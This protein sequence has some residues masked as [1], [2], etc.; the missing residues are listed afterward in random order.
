MVHPLAKLG[1]YFSIPGYF[2][3]ERKNRHRETFKRIPLDRLLI[4][5][6]APDQL[7]PT[8][9]NRFPLSD[10]EGKP[11]NHPANI[12]E[13]YAFVADLLNA[14]VEQVAAKIAQNFKNLFGAS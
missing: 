4:E 1:A 5:T 6:D 11:I 13:V 14:P 8:E 7:L 10:T 3:N 9:L 2:A 12:K